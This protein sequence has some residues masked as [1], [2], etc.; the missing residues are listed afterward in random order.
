MRSSKP[1]LVVVAFLLLFALSASSVLATTTYLRGY[2]RPSGDGGACPSSPSTSTDPCVGDDG[3]TLT[4]GVMDNFDTYQLLSVPGITSGTQV[5]FTFASAAPGTSTTAVNPDGAGTAF[6]S[7]SVLVCAYRVPN[8]QTSV[9][10][11][12]FDSSLN[13]E[14]SSC[15]QMGG[16]PGTSAFTNPLN[17]ITEDTCTGP[18]AANMI[19]LKF[20]QPT[21]GPTIPGTWVFAEDISTTTTTVDITSGNTITTT[22][23]NGPAFQG[24]PTVISPTTPTPE[25][26]SVSLLMAGLVG[27]GIFRRKRAA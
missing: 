23:N 15:T 22:T 26:A 17:F 2:V 1:W 19:C 4:N 3:T 16:N 8:G 20:T 18:N 9:Q 6:S 7:F 25:P 24:S 21:L 10:P 13:L 11:G 14:N 12:I 5:D 27:L